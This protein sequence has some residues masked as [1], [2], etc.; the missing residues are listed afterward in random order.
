M[1]R[2][3]IES[4]LSWGLMV[5]LQTVNTTSFHSSIVHKSILDGVFVNVISSEIET[6]V[7]FE[8]K[9][10]QQLDEN[11]Q[12]SYPRSL[13]YHTTLDTCRSYSSDVPL[14][15]A[16]GINPESFL[17]NCVAKKWP[18]APVGAPHGVFGRSAIQ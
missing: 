13:V 17:C 2:K 16:Y 5:G 12:N 9:L 4:D 8:T 7:E 11:A 18:F 6:G 14:L 1:R 3:P 15:F 10:V